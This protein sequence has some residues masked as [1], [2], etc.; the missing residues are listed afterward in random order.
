MT[1]CALPM[2][3]I[4]KKYRAWSDI[5]RNQKISIG[6]SGLG[7]TSHLVAMEIARRYPNAIVVPYR[8][9]IEASLDVMSGNTDMAVGFLGEI[10]G[11]LDRGDLFALGAT[12]RTTVRGIATLESQ[13][14]TGMSQ[15]VNMHS[16]QVSTAMPEEQYTELRAMV[17]QA[18]RADSVQRAYA[19]DHCEPSNLDT[20]AT[21]RWFESQI[22]LW[23]RLAQNVQLNK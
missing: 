11:F 16:L 10:S 15:V 1:Q 3:M 13:G 8:G 2:V 23:K 5:D 12:G 4:S 19:L 20:A 6:V 14:F 7:T 22:V 18:A 9:G 17:T 21:Q